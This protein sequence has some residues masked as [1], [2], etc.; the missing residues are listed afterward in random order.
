MHKYKFSILIRVFCHYFQNFK[1]FELP[2]ARHLHYDINHFVYCQAYQNNFFVNN[3]ECFKQFY[4]DFILKPNRFKMN[5]YANRVIN[6]F[7][8]FVNLCKSLKSNGYIL[9]TNNYTDLC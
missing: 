7:Y 9:V 2:K 1:I 3:N 8:T 4:S 5:I 6:Q